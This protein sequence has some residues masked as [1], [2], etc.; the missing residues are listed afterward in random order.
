MPTFGQTN[1]KSLSR[2]WQGRIYIEDDSWCIYAL[3]CAKL[4]RRFPDWSR[5]HQWHHDHE[6]QSSQ[7]EDLSLSTERCPYLPSFPI[8]RWRHCLVPSNAMDELASGLQPMTPWAAWNWRL[9]AGNSPLEIRASFSWQVLAFPAGHRTVLFSF[10]TP[11]R[12]SQYSSK[13][14]PE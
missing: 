8:P 4:L 5:L 14:F 7:H 10:C 2:M 13:L 1:R 12:P 9:L 6:Q 11:H 3:S